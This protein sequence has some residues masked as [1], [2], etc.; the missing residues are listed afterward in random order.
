MRD[1]K[2]TIDKIT[3]AGRKMEFVN[4]EKRCTQEPVKELYILNW[5]VGILSG[6]PVFFSSFALSLREWR[7]WM[8]WNK[9]VYPCIRNQDL[10]HLKL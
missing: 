5:G 4:S 9:H 1:D 10:N 6:W 2:E 3:I 8:K 7:H